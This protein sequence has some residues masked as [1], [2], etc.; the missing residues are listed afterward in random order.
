[1]QGDDE[2]RFFI[3][4]QCILCFNIYGLTSVDEVLVLQAPNVQIPVRSSAVLPIQPNTANP[5]PNVCRE[6]ALL[7]NSFTKV[8]VAFKGKPEVTF[9]GSGL[10]QP[11]TCTFFDAPP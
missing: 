7:I 3:V 5:I 1:M 10:D 6:L 2:A 4:F 8:F 9:F 11:S